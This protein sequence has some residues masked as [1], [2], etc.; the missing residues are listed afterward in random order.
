MRC[1]LC[2][3][4]MLGKFLVKAGPC[5]ATILD[6]LEASVVV[7]VAGFRSLDSCRPS[8]WLP[9]LRWGEGW[10]RVPGRLLGIV[11]RKKGWGR[12]CHSEKILILGVGD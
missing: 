11:R 6:R 3:M 1:L 7:V 9:W 8:C 4:D 10:R 5:G 12:V 2:G